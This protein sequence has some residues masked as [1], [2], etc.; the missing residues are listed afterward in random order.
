MI[1]TTTSQ[2][3]FWFIIIILNTLFTYN[4]GTSLTL[5]WINSN[6]YTN[7]TSKRLNQICLNR[8]LISIASNI[9]QYSIWVLYLFGF[10]LRF[11]RLE[12]MPYW[13]FIPVNLIEF[14]C[15]RSTFI[16]YFRNLNFMIVW[17]DPKKNW[18]VLRTRFRNK[19]V[20]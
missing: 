15:N 14:F 8:S 1:S 13:I 9:N 10:F 11:F 7:S 4:I 2:Q 3:T 18:L 6:T 20:K 5:N 19:I 12:V 16:K 17:T